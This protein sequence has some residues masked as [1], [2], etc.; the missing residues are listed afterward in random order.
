MSFASL[1]WE[2]ALR[3]SIPRLSA[4]SRLLPRRGKIKR[5]AKVYRNTPPSR[6]Y[7][8]IGFRCNGPPRAMRCVASSRDDVAFN[9]ASRNTGRTP[10]FDSRWTICRDRAF[11][12]RRAR[13]NKTPSAFH[14]R[15]PFFA[16]VPDVR[17]SLD[18]S[19]NTRTRV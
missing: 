5:Y 12:F 1:A 19:A 13:G 6:R 15:R 8:E 17:A 10:R 2:D 3:F 14:F 18:A 4:L 7:D 16:R 9:I 11:V